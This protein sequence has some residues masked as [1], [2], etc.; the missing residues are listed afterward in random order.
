MLAHLIT[1]EHR[2]DRYKDLEAGLPL[3]IRE[4]RRTVFA[5]QD[6]IIGKRAYAAGWC[7]AILLIGRKALATKK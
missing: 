5:S 2:R 7:P 6:A 3:P 4:R 1:A